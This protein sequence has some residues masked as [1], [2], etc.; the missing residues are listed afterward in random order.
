M[1]KYLKTIAV[2]IVLIASIVFLGCKITAS[3]EFNEVETGIEEADHEESESKEIEEEVS[4][5]VVEEEKGE[6]AEAIEEDTSEGEYFTGA[7]LESIDI[8]NNKIVVTQL[9]N[10]PDEK[11]IEPEVVL[12]PDYRVV[13]S[14]LDIEAGEEEY[15]DITLEDI[16]P[17]SEIGILF[18]EDDTADL[19]I[20]QIMTESTDEESLMYALFD[21]LDA[22]KQDSEYEYFSSE[23]INMVGS[24]EEYKN[25]DRS[26]I[27]FI[28]QESHSNWENIEIESIVIIDN[29]ATVE[30]MGDRMAEG[31][32]SE[33]EKVVFDFVKENGN[34]VIDFSS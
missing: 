23:T 19:I 2:I 33:G 12:S 30:I 11:I 6:D 29:T 4:D 24:E 3:D 22:V 15:S 26:D 21:F 5:G 34:W 1:Y 18:N 9:I 25:G 10:D 27:Y 16:P 14:I 17:G 8:D 13:K 7:I 31:M 32:K 28:I 20:Y